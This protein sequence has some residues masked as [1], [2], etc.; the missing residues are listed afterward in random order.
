[1]KFATCLA[2]STAV[3]ALNISSQQPGP[4]NWI[5]QAL[6]PGPGGETPF[7]NLDKMDGST[8]RRIEKDALLEK[9]AKSK[10]PR[11]STDARRAVK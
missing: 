8:D 3:A 5:N 6:K 7:E 10:L 4:G 2:L 9:L 11:T 1:M